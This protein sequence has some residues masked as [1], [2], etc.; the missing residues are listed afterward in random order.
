[1]RWFPL[2]PQV[3]GLPDATLGLPDPSLLQQGG[4]QDPS[5]VL[6]PHSGGEEQAAVQAL[7]QPED[8][9]YATAA[10]AAQEVLLYQ[11]QQAA[12]APGAEGFSMAAAL[13]AALQ[14]LGAVLVPP[15]GEGA[16]GEAAGEEAGVAAAV[17]GPGPRGRTK[18]CTKCQQ[19]RPLQQFALLKGKKKGRAAHCK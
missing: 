3:V 9:A 16:A 17:G 7:V 15:L 14:G 10:A 18:L 12:A 5:V 19:E 13:D 1:M 11:Q 6:L 2:C 8:V 4:E